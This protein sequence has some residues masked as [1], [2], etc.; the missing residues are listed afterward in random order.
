M[1][2]PDEAQLRE[3][4]A[5]LERQN[6]ALRKRASAS[7]AVEV[8]MAALRSQYIDKR[9]LQ[10]D[11]FLERKAARNMFA[12]FGKEGWKSRES[13]CNE[14]A[15]KYGLNLDEELAKGSSDR[16]GEREEGS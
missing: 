5:E 2:S 12:D 8:Q 7:G 15:K 4:I 3:S 10:R 11:L 9:R 6:E 16:V 14:L 13:L 1:T